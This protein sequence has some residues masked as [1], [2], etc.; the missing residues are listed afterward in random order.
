[1][2]SGVDEIIDFWFSDAADSSEALAQR[3]ALWFGSGRDFDHEVRARFEATI[4]L[5]TTGA[6]NHWEEEPRGLL[7][8]ILLFDQFTRNIHR[9]T[10]EAF[11]HDEA[12]LR[13]CRESIE[14]G[15]DRQL[16]ALER[17]FLYM[18]LQH[19][20]DPE[21]QALSVK[22]TEALLDECPAAQREYFEASHRYAEDHHDVI[23]RFGRFPHRNEVLGRESTAEEREYLQGGGSR[24]GQ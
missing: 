5:A 12:A 17:I 15:F 16:P 2:L 23:A 13:L 22:L 1:M 14:R 4:E 24:F 11:A 9:G 10:R 20:E 8:L 6:C 21:G 3:N 19:V 18:P 7:A